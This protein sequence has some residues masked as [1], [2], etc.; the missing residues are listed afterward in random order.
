MQVIT[1]E[2][3]ELNSQLHKDNVHYGMSGGRNAYLVMQL[4]LELNTM[5]ILDYGCGKSKLA[6]N[7]PFKIKQYDPAIPKY[8]DPV[9]GAR[10]IVVCTD[11]LEHIEPNCLDDVLKHLSLLVKKVGYFTVATRPAKKT[12]ADGRNAHLIVQPMH[13]WL[14]KLFKFFDIRK[15]EKKEGEFI[16]I[17]EPIG[18]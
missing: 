13:W 3:R 1:K 17:V 9:L 14:Q 16:V 8:A 2:Y 18:A 5:D 11:V 15:L 6:H 7:L 12:L 10:D 4:A